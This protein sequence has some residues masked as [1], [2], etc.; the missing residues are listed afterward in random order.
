MTADASRR[1]RTALDPGGAW[2]RAAI[3]RG[4]AHLE[5]IR[6]TIAPHAGMLIVTIDQQ[7][8]RAVARLV[9][10]VTGEEPV[11]AIS[12]DPQASEKIR[13]FGEGEGR[14]LVAVRLV[15]EGVDLPRLYVG[16]YASNIVTEI[17][18]R[19]LLGRLLRQEPGIEGQ[20]AALILPNDPRLAAYAARVMEERDQALGV[21]RDEGDGPGTEGGS[22][23]P[24]PGSG[25]VPLLSEATEGG[26]IHDGRCLSPLILAEAER[27]CRALGRTAPADVLFAAQLLA[28]SGTSAEPEPAAAADIPLYALRRALRNRRQVLVQL[29]GARLQELTGGNE[30]AIYRIVNERVADQIGATV[31]EATVEQLQAQVALLLSWAQQA[32]RALRQG[33]GPEWVRLW[34]GGA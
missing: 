12:D 34:A 11:L 22:A 26:T 9:R 8:A 15:A 32:R 27:H 4:H 33:V 14:I 30:S 29:F 28:Q 25:F 2:L 23:G 6:R 10:E 3:G 18:F 7:H 17:Y 13:R 5:D 1:L 24:R 21:P 20:V 19:Q 16:L 31:G